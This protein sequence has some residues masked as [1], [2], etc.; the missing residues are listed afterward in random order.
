MADSPTASTGSTMV[1][2]VAVEEERVF[3]EQIVELSNHRIVVV[4][5]PGFELAQ[6]SLEL[7]GINAAFSACA[8][9]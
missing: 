7:C 9:P 6:S 5:G 3:A 2:P 4:N 1:E 8:C